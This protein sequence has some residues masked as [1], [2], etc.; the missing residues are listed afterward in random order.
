[1]ENAR[2]GGAWLQGRLTYREIMPT[3]MKRV[4]VLSANE[5]DPNRD[6]LTAKDCLRQ[7]TR[8]RLVTSIV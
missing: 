5:A 2:S 7:I 6:A 1:M 4:S 3:D 8:L